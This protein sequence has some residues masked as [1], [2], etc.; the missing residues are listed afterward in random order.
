MSAEWVKQLKQAKQEL[1]DRQATKALSTITGL[2]ASLAS[3]HPSSDKERKRVLDLHYQALLLLGL[4][5]QR[6]H[7]LPLARQA[8]TQATQ[9]Q[10]DAPA[11]YKALHEL[12]SALTRDEDAIL[13]LV[14]NL[15]PAMQQAPDNK[16]IAYIVQVSQL[17][18]ERGRWKEARELLYPLLGLSA[19]SEEVLEDGP[20]VDGRTFLPPAFFRLCFG[21][22]LQLDDEEKARELIVRVERQLRKARERREEEKMARERVEAKRQQLQKQREGKVTLPQLSKEERERQAKLERDEDDDVRRK[23]TLKLNADWLRRED[24]EQRLQRLHDW[25]EGYGMTCDEACRHREEEAWVKRKVERT[26]LAASAE[27]YAQ[28]RAAVIVACTDMSK[29]HPTSAWCREQLAGM[30]M[31]L[32]EEHKE[33]RKAVLLHSLRYVPTSATL[34]QALALL[35]CGWDEDSAQAAR[36]EVI[37]LLLQQ[38]P[39]SAVFPPSLS[40][41]HFWARYLAAYSL[42]RS[43][44]TT[45]HLTSCIQSI[46]ST[47]TDLTAYQAEHPHH[48]LAGCAVALQ[49]LHADVLVCG[50]D[51]QSVDDAAALYSTF[52]GDARTVVRR[53]AAYGLMKAAV[54]RRSMEPA[55]ALTQ[56]KR[57]REEGGAN[58]NVVAWLSAYIHFSR[59]QHELTLRRETVQHLTRQQ[60]MERRAKDQALL[61]QLLKALVNAQPSFPVLLLKGKVMWELSGEYRI[62][63]ERAYEAFVAAL[64]QHA[65]S[66]SHLSPFSMS[67]VLLSHSDCFAY[68]GL[69]TQHVLHL[70]LKARLFYQK[71]LAIQPYNPTAGPV[72]A[73]LLTQAEQDSQ[74]LSLFASAVRSDSRCRWAYLLSARYH[75]QHGMVQQGIAQ[76][77]HAL[78]SEGKGGSVW[79]ELGGAYFAVGSFIAALRCWKRAVEL[80]EEDD[81]AQYGIAQVWLM[82]AMHSQAIDLLQSLLASYATLPNIES[83]TDFPDLPLDE[84]SP[85]RS[86]PVI[87][88][89]RLLADAHYSHAVVRCTTG[90]YTAALASVSSSIVTAL[91]CLPLIAD[92]SSPAQLGGAYKALADAHF[93]YSQLPVDSATDLIQTSTEGQTP[94]KEKLRLLLLADRYYAKAIHLHPTIPSLWYDRGVTNR[95]LT[96]LTSST[97]LTSPSAYHQ[98]ATSCLKHAVRLAPH[99]SFHW[100]ALSTTLPSFSSRHHSLVQ[101]IRAQKNPTAWAHLSL[102]Y[103]QHGGGTLTTALPSHSAGAPTFEQTVIGDG[104]PFAHL[105]AARLSLQLA[106]TMDPLHPAVWLAQGLFN[107]SFEET[108]VLANAAG[109]FGRSVE[110]GPTYD[111][112]VGLAWCSVMVQDW[113][114][115][116][117]EA[118]KLV[119]QWPERSA[120]WNLHGACCEW[121]SRHAEAEAAYHTAEQ[122]MATE[123]LPIRTV[124]PQQKPTAEERA[125]QLLLRLIRVNR[126]RVLCALARYAES[127]VLAQAIMQEDVA[128]AVPSASSASL[129]L[130]HLLVEVY[131]KGAQYEEGRRVVVAAMELVTQ[132]RGELSEGEES[133]AQVRQLAGEYHR[134][135]VH[136]VQLLLYEGKDDEALHHLQSKV[137]QEDEVGDGSVQEER[138]LELLRLTLKVGVKRRDAGILQYAV[139]AI[140][141]S[142]YR[143]LD[144]SSPSTHASVLRSLHVDS[145]AP[146][147]LAQG[148]LSA[149]KRA[150]LKA[151]TLEPTSTSA[152]NAFLA[153]HL[154]HFPSLT[155]DVLP[156]ITQPHLQGLHLHL[157]SSVIIRLRLVAQAYI[158]TNRF[159]PPSA[160]LSL[161]YEQEEASNRAA[162]EQQLMTHSSAEEAAADDGADDESTGLEADEK[163][164]NVRHDAPVDPALTRLAA[165]ASSSFAFDQSM[166]PPSSRHAVSAAARLVLLDPTAREHWALLATAAEGR[167][168]ERWRQET[169]SDEGWSSVVSCSTHYS[170]LLQQQTFSHLSPLDL[171]AAQQEVIE[172]SLLALLQTVRVTSHI[173]GEAGREEHLRYM[174]QSMALIPEDRLTSPP[175]RWHFHRCRARLLLSQLDVDAALTEYQRCIELAIDTQGASGDASPTTA[176]TFASPLSHAVIWEE[177]AL[178]MNSDEEALKSGLSLLDRLHKEQDSSTA[179]SSAERSYQAERLSLILAVLD[180]Y[181]HTERWQAG[182]AFVQSELPFLS[183]HPSSSPLCTSLLLCDWME[184]AGSPR[185]EWRKEAK[186]LAVQWQQWE[187]EVGARPSLRWEQPLPARTHWHL[188]QLEA[189]RQQ[190]TAAADQLRREQQ[191]NPHIT[192]EPDFVRLLGDVKQRLR[193]AHAATM[194]ASSS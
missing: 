172:S 84:D 87:A 144:T 92:S 167:E 114:T 10:P 157:D 136:F 125:R 156:L 194:P 135:F 23:V 59:H 33:G 170:L 191:I 104:S 108:D 30:Q 57:W 109:C 162:E 187:N 16:R 164:D 47:L 186:A 126:A 159:I 124:D 55:A 85:P 62:D 12:H 61:Q 89:T 68:L 110:L 140:A 44:S 20:A 122:L 28:L 63:K 42:F 50:R 70:P 111:A 60:R 100:L 175:L 173:R 130:Y 185:A 142:T 118:R 184:W 174:Q 152:W 189:E 35:L 95:Q 64:S 81:A 112:R 80:N 138:R 65:S 137:Q 52:V 119:E 37:R 32:W 120:G 116:A 102:F 94:S 5:Q 34:H 56:V 76:Y 96:L 74:L 66:S 171:P 40:T 19:Q 1:D 181:Q 168:R 155:S 146:A 51:E 9:L 166:A 78:R 163:D 127:I 6:L 71:A 48:P 101:A 24:N 190:W 39:P 18:L 36:D 133:E 22:F 177:V 73:L 38:H 141:K 134:F 2:L 154:R 11:A 29:T 150:L 82:L 107:S 105:D 25:A 139:E 58:A 8:Y 88:V 165:V 147:A 86:P 98:R 169:D 27:E 121:R 91:S 193:D 161:A 99:N 131:T 115:A 41:A 15:L 153:F 179:S 79:S 49:L 149:A 17:L 188:A 77:Q 67:S 13:A 113:L 117:H 180:C 132:A 160:S 7:R 192:E 31:E 53:C 54:L 69:Y 26:N 97:T 14:P 128:L 151:V 123:S 21:L 4:I 158:L 3:S 143:L 178:V 72:L 83:S 93:L 182:L 183:S 129:Y 45:T 145:E 46:Q 106:Q 43:A 148:D 75:V 176:A 90:A 103:L